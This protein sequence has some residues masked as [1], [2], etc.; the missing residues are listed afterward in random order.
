MRHLAKNSM[1]AQKLMSGESLANHSD[2][3]KRDL[4]TQEELMLR[5]SISK[6]TLWRYRNGGMPNMKIGKKIFYDLNK[7]KKYI[8]GQSNGR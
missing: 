1:E 6:T 2:E 8:G 5:L 7:V 3:R 4:I